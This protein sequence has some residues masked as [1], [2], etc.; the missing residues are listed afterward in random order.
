MFLLGFDIYIHRC[1]T[2]TQWC[3][4]NLIKMFYLHEIG[5]IVLILGGI[6]AIFSKEKKQLPIILV[7]SIVSLTLIWTSYLLYFAK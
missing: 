5:V 3:C 2:T 7:T 1:S 4:Q 6:I